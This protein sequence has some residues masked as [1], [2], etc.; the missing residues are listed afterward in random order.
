MLS[1]N[2]WFWLALVATIGL[3]KLELFATFLNLSALSP[4]I[5]ERLRHSMNEEDHE[6]MLEYTRISAKF[7]VVQS[8]I[9]LVFFLAFWWI[10]GFSLLDN[11]LQNLQLGELQ[12]G[13]LTIAIVFLAQSLLSLPFEI[14]DTFFIEAHFGFNKTTATTFMLDRLKGLLLAGVLGIPLVTLLLWLF[15]NVPYAAAYGWLSVS[16]FSLLMTFLAPRFIL[17]LFYQF[18]PLEE[19]ALREAIV[20]MGQRL[21]F[22]VGEISIVDGSSRSTKANAFFTGLGNTKRIALFDTLL[23]HHTRDEILAVLAHEIGH[24]KRRHVPK[25]LLLSLGTTALMFALLH[26]TMH[27]ARICAAFGVN[28]PTVAWNMIFFS[29]LYHPISLILGLMSS[30]LSRKFEFE[31]DSFAR[32]AMGNPEPLATALIKLTKDHLGNPTPHPFYVFLNYSHP[33]T[34]QRLAAL[35]D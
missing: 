20:K 15:Q 9:P 14:Y 23:N 17:P 19:P 26:V 10:G 12:T 27:D 22:P 24:C 13:L 21:D 32:E 5:P 33:T 25:Q 1:S 11:R 30:C 2:P 18:K 29:I 16:A 35:E 31:A 6:Q 8:S 7:D 28:T 3:Y 4:T 34:L